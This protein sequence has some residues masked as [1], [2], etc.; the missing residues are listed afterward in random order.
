MAKRVEIPG[1]ERIADPQ[2]QLVGNVDKDKPI[3]VTVYL[4][5]SGSLDW[6]DRRSR[7]AP[8]GATDALAEGAC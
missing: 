6:V 3:E 5:P 7:S 2:H 1:S 4:R 8:V